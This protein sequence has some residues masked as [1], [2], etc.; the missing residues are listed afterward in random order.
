M[1]SFYNKIEACELLEAVITARTTKGPKV[2]QLAYFNSV[3]GMSDLCSVTEVDKPRCWKLTKTNIDDNS[4][5]EVVLRIQ[6]IVCNASLP[7][8]KRPFKIEPKQRRY[9]KQSLALTGL[10]GTKFSTMIENIYDIQHIFERSLPHNTMDAW[11]P[12]YYETFQALDMGNRYFTDRRDINSDDPISFGTEID[13][14]NILTNALSNEFVHLLENK[15]DYYEAQQG[16]DNII[17]YYEINPMK[18]HPGDVVEVQVSFVAIPLKQQRYKLLVVLRAITLLDCS[19]LR[20][21][22]IAR[23]MSRGAEPRRAS[24]SLKRKI[25]Y[26]EDEEHD[27]GE[28]LSKMRLD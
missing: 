5:E 7:P 15:V 19:P 4:Q 17:R 11:V 25:G 2:V 24:Q 3:D 13:P 14:H 22:S 27:T 6:G 16:T 18:I 21:A 28:K 10:G 9:L 12:S 23:C 8:V 1:D 26:E 20:N